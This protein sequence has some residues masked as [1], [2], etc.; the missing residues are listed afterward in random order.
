MP[1]STIVVVVGAWVVL[2]ALTVLAYRFNR[3]RGDD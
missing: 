2:A 3:D 1:T